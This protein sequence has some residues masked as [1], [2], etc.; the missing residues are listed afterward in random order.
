MAG[1]P[2][3]AG[4][5]TLHVVATPIGNLEDIT[6]RALRVLGEVEAIACEDTRQTLK[7]LNRY[8]IRKRLISYYEPREKRKIPEILGVLRRGGNVALVTD[9]GTP[10]ISDP[11]F[12]L[13]RE[14]LREGFAVTPI[15]GP[16]ALTA[17]LCA[18]GLPT[19]RVLFIGFPP[20]KPAALRKLFESL[21]EEAATLVFYVPT[22]KAAAFLETAA[23]VLGDR[24]AVLARE[25]TKIHEEFRR[26]TARELADSLGGTAVR[27]EA[28]ILIAGRE[29]QGAEALCSDPPK[30]S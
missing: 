6:L 5:G 8:G 16:S 13:V 30:R 22:R 12:T 2:A 17:A 18:A 15:P 25:L 1:G 21:R 3:P 28:T 7:L 4:R 11:G 14:A 27:G 23:E 9:A 24:P 20:P 29:R 26:A 10:G 19:H